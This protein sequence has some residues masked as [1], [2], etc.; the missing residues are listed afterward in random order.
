MEEI[1]SFEFSNDTRSLNP[2]IYEYK[3]DKKKVTKID[4]PDSNGFV[5]IHKNNSETE[6]IKATYM[7][8]CT[9]NKHD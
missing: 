8:L 1:T 3:V 2:N 9:N 6:Y 5:A 7:K 4:F